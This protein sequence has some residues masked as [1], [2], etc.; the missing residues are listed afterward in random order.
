MGVCL[1]IDPNLRGQRP[2]AICS[3][4]LENNEII[5]HKN[6]NESYHNNIQTCNIKIL[7]YIK[8]L[9]CYGCFH[10]KKFFK[11]KIDK[12]LLKID[13][14]TTRLSENYYQLKIIR[15]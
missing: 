6:N 5:Q 2:F 1:Q 8:R 10:T 9:V 13:H 4:K 11:I 3:N 15:E 7:D 14:V 12:T